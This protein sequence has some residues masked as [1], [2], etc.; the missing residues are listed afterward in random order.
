MTKPEGD[1]PSEALRLTSRLAEGVVVIHVAGILDATTRQRFTG[2][3]AEAGDA[4]G[5]D[6]ILDLAGVTFMDSRALGLI[7]HH[8]QL[9]TMAG[10]RYALAGVRYQSAQVMWVTGLAQR[11]PLYDTV[12]DALRAFAG[13]SPVQDGTSPP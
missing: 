5:P 11:L 3:L 4:H 7:V 2:Y 9:A 8:W 10:A 6:M 13:T 12:E 1:G